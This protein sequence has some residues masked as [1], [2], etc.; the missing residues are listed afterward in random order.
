MKYRLETIPEV[1][2]QT[3]VLMS[4][5]SFRQ[6]ID[7]SKK[8]PCRTRPF[9]DCNET[10]LTAILHVRNCSRSR[11]QNVPLFDVQNYFCMGLNSFPETA[12]LMD[13]SIEGNLC[14]GTYPILLPYNAT[15]IVV[16]AC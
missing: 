15:G 13:D 9:A 14:P 1:T 10:S 7:D 12:V 8:I 6:V 16:F 2:T 11:Q 3:S 5:L 4:T